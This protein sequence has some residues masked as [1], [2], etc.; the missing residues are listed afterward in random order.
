MRDKA[1]ELKVFL[2]GIFPDDG[3]KFWL[4]IGWSRILNGYSEADFKAAVSSHFDVE[5]Q[6]K[7]SQRASGMDD[8]SRRTVAPLARKAG[9]VPDDVVG[10]LDVSVLQD[11]VLGPIL[12]D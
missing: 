10:S 11:R 6:T 8:V 3:L 1:G 12:R 7:R 2:S 5:P 4:T 9:L